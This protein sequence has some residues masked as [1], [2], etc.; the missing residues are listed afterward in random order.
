[1]PTINAPT[2][3]VKKQS[4]QGC[5]YFLNLGFVTAAALFVAFNCIIP[6]FIGYRLTT[7]RNRVTDQPDNTLGFDYENVSFST[8]DGLT[9]SAWYIPSRNRAAVIA[10]HGSNG[11]RTGVAQHAALLAQHGY[12]VLMLDLR[13]HGNSEGDRFHWGWDSNSDID[14][15]VAYLQSRMDVDPDR[16]GALGLSMGGEV[17][18]QAAAANSS[19][20]AVLSDGAGARTF[21]DFMSIPGLEKITGIPSMWSQIMTH[22]IVTGVPPPPPLI[23]LIPQIAPRAVFLISR[24]QGGWGERFLTDVYFAAAGEP[25]QMWVIPEAPHVGGITVRPEEYERNVIEFFD[26]ALGSATEQG[27]M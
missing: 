16:I 15:A 9:L 17:V 23:E 19:I 4:R 22:R 21:D 1:M 18:L 24:G 10:I 11:N 20:R 3:S 5:R 12:G 27:D 6:A 14:A 8:A 13:G 7:V 26:Q 25:K 2:T